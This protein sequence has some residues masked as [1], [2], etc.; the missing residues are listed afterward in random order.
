[1]SGKKSNQILATLLRKASEEG[2]LVTSE[3]IFQRVRE[4]NL[5][6]SKEG[7]QSEHEA[8]G[9]LLKDTF[10]SNGD[11]KEISGSDGFP[12]YY[13]SIYMGEAF[14]TLLLKKERGPLVLIAETVRED[15]AVYPRPT[16]RET[17]KH[18]PFKLTEEEIS[19]CLLQMATRE[20]FKDIGQ[21]TTSAGTV[22]LYSA[23]HLDPD[24]ASMLA[25]WVD[26]GQFDNP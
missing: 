7:E 9:T 25:E 12:R 10:K 15:S 2:R 5:L 16:P 13:S 18:P 26:V 3:E 4:L 1:M 17:F 14:A 20:E 22:Y 24:Y 19:A 11:L 23:R 21:T 6:W 8:Y